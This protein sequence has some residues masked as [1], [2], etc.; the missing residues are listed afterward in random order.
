MRKLLTIF[1]LL[2]C[3][4]GFAATPT[5]VGTP[6]FTNCA[7]ATTCASGSVTST[8]GNTM[9]VGC[10]NGTVAATFSAADGTNTYTAVGSG[11]STQTSEGAMRWFIAKNITGVTHVL[12]CTI[13][14][15]VSAFSGTIVYQIAGASTT[16]P[17]DVPNTSTAGGIG[18]TSSATPSFTLP[19]TTNSKDLLIFA[20]S[21]SNT[22]TAGTGALNTASD[23]NGDLSE[24]YAKSATGTYTGAFAQTAGAFLV[25]GVA[26]SDGLG[27]GGA[28][29][30]GI[31]KQQK[32]EK[33][34]PQ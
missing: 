29:I 23:A 7:S 20:A 34:W 32:L 27:G 6:T 31:T 17:L 11:T 15:G 8:T 9:V 28:A 33:L 22:C 16:T 10:M 19:A 24:T 26:I 5:V 21:C 13:T 18:G 12:T 3:V 14:S 2:I 1:V 25:I 30:I 4:A